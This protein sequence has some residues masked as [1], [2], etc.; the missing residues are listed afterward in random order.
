METAIKGDKQGLGLTKRNKKRFEAQQM[1]I[2]LGVLAH[3][4][5]VWTRHWL[6]PYVPWLKRWG[7]M[8]LVRDVGQV[9]GRLGF[10]SQQHI[11]HIILNAADPLAK[12]LATGLNVLLEAEHIAVTLGEI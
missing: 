3:N 6:T 7:I 4:T 9:S 8:R 1:L 5:M 10:D 2:Q 11:V 12:A